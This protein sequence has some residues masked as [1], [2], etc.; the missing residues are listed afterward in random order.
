MLNYTGHSSS[1]NGMILLT[2]GLVATV[3]NDGYLKVWYHTTGATSLSVSVG[4]ALSSV[5]QVSSNAIAVGTGTYLIK[6]YTMDGVSTATLTGHV[7]SIRGIRLLTPDVLVSTD[8]SGYL[9][10][11]YL[12]NSTILYN[13]KAHTGMINQ[14]DVASDYSIVTLST[15]DNFVEY[16]QF[17][18]TTYEPKLLYTIPTS[19][20]AVT[21][22]NKLNTRKL[23]LKSNQIIYIRNIF[24][25]SS[26]HY[27]KSR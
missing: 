7:N 19:P 4:V 10:T 1:I 2:S 11:W 18:T 17:S 8:S 21:F 26:K 3:G 14:F 22:Y 5:E 13:I 23:L 25:D 15:G 24:S 16:Y 27:F 9:I 12:P 20:Q 6:I